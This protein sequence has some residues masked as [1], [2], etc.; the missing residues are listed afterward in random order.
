MKRVWVTRASP[1]AEETAARLRALGFEPVID[2]LL[3]VRSLD[4]GPIDL[5]GVGALAFTSANGVAAFAER[6]DERSLTVFAVGDATAKA[7]RARGFTSVASADGDV[8]ALA[9]TIAA[10]ADL[11]GAVLHLGPVEAAG[12]LAGDLA[13]RGVAAR[14]LALYETA[15]LDTATALDP[16][17]DAV[18]LHSPKAA[19]ALAGLL[20]GGGMIAV[21]LSPAVAEPLAST[22]LAAVAVA[23]RPNEAALLKRLAAALA[24]GPP[25]ADPPI[26]LLSGGFWLMMAFG[27]VCLAAALAVALFGPRLF[28]AH[29]P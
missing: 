7:A 18:L 12:D 22:T 17:P 5:A 8:A 28:P 19:R 24:E 29:P 6:S 4:G 16:P 11:E 26:R 15:V 14:A 1:G 27:G 13:A 21:C 2:P 3:E 20:K 23:D 25:K 10:R 9:R